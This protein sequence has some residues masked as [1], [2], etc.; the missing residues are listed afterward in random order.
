MAFYAKENE[1][2]FQ[3]A[4]MEGMDL[5]V[6]ILSSCWSVNVYYILFFFFF[7]QKQK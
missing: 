5:N 6:C 3:L 2:L 1:E 7:N 4:K